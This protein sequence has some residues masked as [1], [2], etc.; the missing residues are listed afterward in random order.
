MM[1][2]QRGAAGQEFGLFLPEVPPLDG[3]ADLPTVWAEAYLMTLLVVGHPGTKF[4][5]GVDSVTA[6]Y[7]PDPRGGSARWLFLSGMANAPVPIRLGYRVT[8]QRAES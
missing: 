6:S 4:E 7:Q 2:I 8:V 1:I 3:E 5:V